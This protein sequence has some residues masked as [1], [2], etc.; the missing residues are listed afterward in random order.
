MVEYTREELDDALL[1]ADDAGDAKAVNQLSKM[2]VEF[3][4]KQGY[5]PKDYNAGQMFE[6]AFESVGQ[7]VGQ[8]PEKVTEQ[9]GQV[10]TQEAPTLDTLGMTRKM[11]SDAVFPILGSAAN[12]V[13]TSIGEGIKLGGKTLLQLTPDSLEKE[14]ADRVMNG[15]NTIANTSGGEKALEIG[16]SAA[17][18]GMGA[19]QALRQRDPILT[20]NIQGMFQVAEIYKPAAM[21]KPVPVETGLREKAKDL[22][23]RGERM[24]ADQRKAEVSKALEPLE[25]GKAAEER[26]G[27]T[28][29]DDKGNATYIPTVRE[30]AVIKTVSDN[31]KV[32]ASKTNQQN[33]NEL[34]K[35]IEKT[36]QELDADL[37]RA[38]YV[39]MNTG[40]LSI[41]LKGIVDDLLRNN[42]A[43][44]G[45]AGVVAE[46]LFKFVNGELKKSDGTP[47]SLMNI[48]RSLDKKIEDAGKDT[49]DGN[50]NGYAI[51]QRTV[52]N[53]LNAKVSEAVPLAPVMESLAK[54]SNL[55]SAQDILRPKAAK[56]ANT[57]MGIHLQ[58]IMRAVDVNIPKSPVGKFL[59]V[60]GAYQVL[61][62]QA[63]LEAIPMIGGAAVVGSI[64]Y[65]V[66]RGSV[67]PDLRKALSKLLK[68]TDQAIKKT[69][70]REMEE[71]LASD[72]AFIVEIMKLPTANTQDLTKEEQEYE[73]PEIPLR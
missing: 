53:F 37:A 38:S 10:L 64:G 12:V 49:Y 44:V 3:E 46:K 67:S 29:T 15:L 72:R 13:A 48:R 7:A 33:F 40:S 32:S 20:D 5:Q 47:L 56:D 8:V 65:A 70:L 35:S 2:I 50:E 39:K 57:R 41:E 63:L 4:K 52:R 30:E 51:A 18:A 71:A 24:S 19:W 31:T 26:V 1:L 60:T 23:V 14:V 6:Q 61:T 73:Y 54:Q 9:V 27:R 17:K 59:T 42:P 36:A 62:S 11:P 69:K 66:H 55:F 34:K 25:T 45:D 16:L 21:R 22:Q 43:L 28:V 68:V 58:N